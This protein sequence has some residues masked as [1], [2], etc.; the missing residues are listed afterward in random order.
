MKLGDKRRKF[1][2]MIALLIQY[3]LFMGYEISF[4]KE[5]PHHMRGSLHF[6]GL[7]K[8][9]NLYKDGVYLIMTKEHEAIGKFWEFLGGT[10]GG[11]F[12]DGNH[13]SMAHGGKK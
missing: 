2:V 11:K 5:H 12:D 1:T 13:Y 4:D 3:A 7:A 9:F 10:W 8:D 6:E